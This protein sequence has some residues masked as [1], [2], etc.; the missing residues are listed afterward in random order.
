MSSL[1]AFPSSELKRLPR[2]GSSI[3]FS[4]ILYSLSKKRVAVFHTPQLLRDERGWRRQIG[5]KVVNITH[6]QTPNNKELKQQAENEPVRLSNNIINHGILS[7][8]ASN[9]SDTSTSSRVVH[10]S[11][12]I[13]LSTLAFT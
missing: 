12:A 8:V 1:L 9:L 10:L 3:N 4:G 5:V 2:L 6:T 7:D 11:V 13:Y